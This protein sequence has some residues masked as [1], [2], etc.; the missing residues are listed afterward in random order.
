MTGSSRYDISGFHLPYYGG[1]RERQ[2]AKDQL[3]IPAIPPPLLRQ[4]GR[5]G[6]T[7]NMMLSPAFTD[8]LPHGLTPNAAIRGDQYLL[9]VL[10]KALL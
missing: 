5:R 9:K 1:T 3:A 7:A 2:P 6:R 10:H 4:I 8:Q